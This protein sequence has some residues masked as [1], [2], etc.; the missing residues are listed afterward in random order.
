MKTGIDEGSVPI[1]FGYG[2]PRLAMRSTNSGL[3]LVSLKLCCFSSAMVL[4]VRPTSPELRTQT[5][6]A[7]YI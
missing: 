4:T 6:Y 7:I 1:F 3:D 2:S 5:P